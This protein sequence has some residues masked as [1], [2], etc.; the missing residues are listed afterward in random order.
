MK[1]ALL[2]HA[3]LIETIKASFSPREVEALANLMKRE[4]E[5]SKVAAYLDIKEL[6]PAERRKVAKL[7]KEATPKNVREMNIVA[8]PFIRG[9][10]VQVLPAAK[11]MPA[12]RVQEH[13]LKSAGEAVTSPYRLASLFHMNNLVK[14]A[15]ACGQALPATVTQKI[16][17]PKDDGPHYFLNMNTLEITP[18]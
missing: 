14:I 4:Q 10:L 13:D 9:D 2:S 7:M 11:A 12:T 6:S 1:D 16:E 3:A 5:M 18:A 17:R 15:A 8:D